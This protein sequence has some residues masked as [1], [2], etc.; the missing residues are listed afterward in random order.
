MTTCLV[1]GAS[2]MVGQFLLPRLSA[3]GLRVLAVSRRAQPALPDGQWLQ[4][5]L[6][7]PLPVPPGSEATISCGPPDAFARWYA[8]AAT[9][10]GP[11]V[12]LGSMSAVSKRT[13]PDP[14]ERELA[15]RLVASEQQLLASA[16]QRGARA[17]ILRPTLIYGS[18]RDRSLA[19]I[20][21]FARRW[22]MYPRLHGASGLRQPVHADDLAQA[23]LALLTPPAAGV[24]AVGGGERLDCAQMIERTCCSLEVACLPIPLP[25][26]VLGSRAIAGIARAMGWGALHA[27]SIARLREDLVADN[28]PAARD[29]GWAPRPF[30]PAA[31]SWPRLP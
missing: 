4:A 26:A 2:G 22:R 11:V 24:Y 19:R 21:R 10:A 23:C 16:A 14:L 28:G 13:S 3:A 31:A 9:G 5:A 1:F 15:A 17:V 18:G 12:A 20:A 27:A 25:V 8:D 6:D 29:F 7:Q 30:E